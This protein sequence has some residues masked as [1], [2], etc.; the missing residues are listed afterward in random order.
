[1]SWEV[2]TMRS[3]TSF[4]DFTVFRKNIQRYWPLWGGYLFL[5]LLFL[6]GSLLFMDHR[7]WS[8]EWMEN[9]VQTVHESLAL[10]Q[11]MAFLFG[12]ASAMAVFQYLYNNRAAC[13][14][15][16]LPLRRDTLFWSNYLSGLTF[17][18][19]PH[20]IV[21]F[22]TLGIELLR[23]VTALDSLGVWL[24][25]QSAMCLFFY[26][27]AV[28]CGM[29]T[30]NILALPIFYGILNFLVFYLTET[31]AGFVS[32]FLYGMSLSAWTNHSF[33]HWATPMLQMSVALRRESDA[34]YMD[35]PEILAIYALAGIVLT[36]LALM[37]YKR[38]HIESAGDVVAVRLVRPV[39]Q[40]GVA[41]ST[42]LLGTIL[43]FVFW[44]LSAP[45][46]FTLIVSVVL[47][48]V[49]GYFAATMLL[50]KT[51][52]VFHKWKGAAVL[53]AVLVLFSLALEFDA[54]G[55]IHRVPKVE[56]VQDMSYFSIYGFYYSGT[57][58]TIYVDEDTG[59]G[60]D[61]ARQEKMI[62][63]HQAI[64]DLP[65][66]LRDAS[67]DNSV[68][69][70]LRYKLAN[71][72]ELTRRYYG[73]PVWYKDRDVPGTVAYCIEQ[74]CQ[75]RELLW[76]S[77]GLDQ[78]P[79]ENTLWAE[80]DGVRNASTNQYTTTGSLGNAVSTRLW[81]AV[82]KDFDE[83]T[84]GVQYLFAEEGWQDMYDAILRFYWADPAEDAPAD[85][86][87]YSTRVVMAAISLTPQARHTLAVLEEAGILEEYKLES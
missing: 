26:S 45:D 19:I 1:M 66:D 28:F 61:P 16:A 58:N 37:V 42:G 39:F 43:L 46:H 87:S 36:V 8:V 22:V 33:V 6:P 10:G 32:E 69:V 15:H 31:I 40:Y 17:A 9:A 12:L 74:L 79:E 63:L 44:G 23:G 50:D 73:V 13:M 21:A 59:L 24:L 38:R 64:T 34:V 18:L 2:R 14:I 70:E 60:T 35:R 80:V 72:N 86:A 65:K 51:F 48:S 55:F 68:G 3:G 27:F 7:D 30:G 56:D 49:A 77:Y 82:Q 29:F 5:W 84:I 81:T 67:G 53:S 78:Q 20:L 75:D 71:G 25:G 57:G 85:D 52:R 54:F 47:W 76:H 11:F 83:G 41:I 4:F 62:A